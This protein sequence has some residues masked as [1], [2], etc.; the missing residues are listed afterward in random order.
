MVI[1]T[2]LAAGIHGHFVS[3]RLSGTAAT[4]AESSRFRPGG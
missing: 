1:E 2:G 4:V 3:L